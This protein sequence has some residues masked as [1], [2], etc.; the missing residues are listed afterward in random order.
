MSAYAAVRTA[1]AVHVL[2]D[3]GMYDETKGTLIGTMGKIFLMP[4]QNAVMTQRGSGVVGSVLIPKMSTFGETFDELK[5]RVGPE[6]RD[7]LKPAIETDKAA[8]A[9]WVNFDILIAGIS[10]SR[11]P[12]SY[13]VPSYDHPTFEAIKAWTPFDPGP[14]MMAPGDDRILATVDPA[15]FDPVKDGIR[16]M[17]AQRQ[18]LEP[19]GQSA[20]LRYIVAGFVQLTTVTAG[21]ITTKIIHRWPD[22]IGQ[23]IE[24]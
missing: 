19:Q 24:P 11:G 21:S 16:I 5:A 13:V 12:H 23:K 8:G 14:V 3:G 17:E 9:A 20:E 4:K 22:K 1:D 18:I 6:M 10:E 7:W 2:T 15:T